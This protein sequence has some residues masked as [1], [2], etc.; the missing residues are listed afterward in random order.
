MTDHPSEPMTPDLT[1]V[2]PA[3]G[4]PP[5]TPRS[6]RSFLGVAA[7]ALGALAANTVASVVP[8]EAATGSTVKAGMT[9]TATGTTQFHA[10]AGGATALTGLAKSTTTNA[11]S[12]GV[13]GQSKAPNGT[14][15][16]GIAPTGVVGQ[17]VGVGVSGTASYTAGTGVLGVANGGG[18]AAW[19]VGGLSSSGQGV[20]GESS[21][22]TGIGVYGSA[23]ASQGTG[24]F[25]RSAGA[26]GVGVRGEGSTGV[27]G[28]SEGI[29]V[30]GQGY[31]GVNGRSDTHNGIGVRAYGGTSASF[32]LDA[33]KDGAGYAGRFQGAVLVLGTLAKSAGSFV[34]DHPLDPENRIL[35]HSF[36]ESPEMLN[37]YSGTVRLD[38]KG[39]ATVRLPAY[40]EA[41]NMEH[42]YQLTAIGAPAPELHVA[43]EIEQ[44]RFVIAGG[45]AGQKVCWQVTGV[46]Q[47]AY[48][49]KHR[50]K[51][52]TAK[53]AKDKG[54]LLNPEAFG[55][56]RTDA[57]GYRKP[58]KRAK[59]PKVK[60]A[61]AKAR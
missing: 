44:K 31:V 30:E 33:R 42:R 6:R 29:A 34:I 16:K 7:A 54:R 2:V 55:R 38:G 27:V 12:T 60:D 57:I 1:A 8:V 5:V 52:D 49:R 40:F 26:F 18:T 61:K 53:K 48:A 3:D 41:L 4:A 10:T 46:R 59:A 14:G 24:V 9:N 37:V 43:K 39:R 20:H 22:A 21:A 58:P 11:K 28:I 19:G 36:V 32:A 50:I 23:N 56:P 47:D 25:G 45:V 15:V 17:G 13:V 51:V 35:A